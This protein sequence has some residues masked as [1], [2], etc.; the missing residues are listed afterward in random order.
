MSS[1]KQ[2]YSQSQSQS[3]RNQNVN[4]ASDHLMRLGKFPSR[5]NVGINFLSS[6]YKYVVERF[7][8]FSKVEQPGLCFLIPFVD[9]I[10]YAVDERELCIRIDPELATSKDN[11]QV[12]LGGNLYVQFYDAE[13]AS[14]GASTPIYAV[15]QFAQSVM[16]TAV[17]G[18][19]LDTL[20]S[21]RASL[22]TEVRKALSEGTEKWGCKVIR[23]EITDLEPV[24]QNVAQS[25]HKQSTAEREKREKITSAEA[26]KQETE[27]KADA[28]KYK[29]ITEAQGDA[30]KTKI[31][32]DA[33]A[34]KTLK[35]A[36]AEQEGIRLI[37][38]A[39]NEVGGFESMK[40][41]LS[42]QYFDTLKSLGGKSTI[43]IPQN[44]G[45]V[46]SMVAAG[47]SVFSNLDSTRKDS[48]KPVTNENDMNNDVSSKG[49]RFNMSA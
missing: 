28:Y 49:D 35:R 19:K 12:S 16:R 37:A 30:E 29:Q 32:A 36:E 33:D 1:Q 11:V 40:T 31:A 4:S 10:A 45:D 38:S 6:G 34:Y 9:R 46:A 42:S 48:V 47:Q 24:D 39:M 7:G 23:F 5:S 26:F 18:L 17:G 20:F 14:Y 41:R 22:N 2:T 27:L 43:I 13:K 21:E 44:L 3:Q 25:L 8:K 15:S